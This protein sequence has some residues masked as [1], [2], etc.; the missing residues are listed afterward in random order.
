MVIV[1]IVLASGTVIGG[2][3][4][5]AARRW[6]RPTGAPALAATTVESGV[7]RH[8]HLSKVVEQRADPAELTGLALTVAAVVIVGGLV[9]IGLLFAMIQTDTG[10]ARFDLTFARFGADHASAGST[11]V[12]RAVSLLGGTLGVVVMATVVGVTE[13]VRTRRRAVFAFLG[14]VV[15]GQFLA[16]NLIKMMVGRERPDILHLTGFSGSSFP[17]GHASAAAATF[18]AFALLLGRGRSS[19]A[20][21]LLTGVAAGI[22]GAVAATRVLLGVHWFTD[23]L[24]GLLLGW[25]WFA[26]FSIAFGGRILRFGAPVEQAEAVADQPSASTGQGTNTS[27]GRD[28]STSVGSSAPLPKAPERLSPQQ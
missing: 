6:P 15:G 21:A 17:S 22:A 28:R 10:L 5:L 16:A 14:V 23:V 20:K 9:G 24:A 26:T 7:E 8:P 25:L 18:M 1:A 19:S 13:Y 2:A 27:T 3:A 12:L 4:Y 11:D